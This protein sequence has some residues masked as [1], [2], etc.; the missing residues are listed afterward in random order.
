VSNYEVQRSEPTTIEEEEAQL[1][2]ALQA[3][4]FDVRVQNNQSEAVEHITEPNTNV[5]NEVENDAANALIEL[6]SLS[7]GNANTR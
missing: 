2:L 4:S 7:N 1:E 3:S 6:M 5:A